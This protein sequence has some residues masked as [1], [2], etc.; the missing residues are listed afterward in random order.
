[1]QQMRYGLRVQSCMRHAL[2]G[3]QLLMACLPSEWEELR[4][5]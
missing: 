2:C 4:S 1:M 3:W 5:V